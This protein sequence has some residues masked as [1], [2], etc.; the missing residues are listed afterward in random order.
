MRDMLASIATTGG[1]AAA[2]RSCPVPWDGT[3]DSGR[4]G[5]QDQF[6]TQWPT[7]DTASVP[8]C[9][10]Q[11]GNTNMASKPTRTFILSSDAFWGGGS[12]GQAGSTTMTVTASLSIVAWLCRVRIVRTVYAGRVDRDDVGAQPGRS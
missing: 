10:L 2:E 11:C 5:V 3:R 1:R 9:H 8:C 6:S 4:V 7:C 12:G